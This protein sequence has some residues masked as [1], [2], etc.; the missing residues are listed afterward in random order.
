MDRLIAP[1]S[2]TAGAADVAPA[3][4]TPGFATDG[5]PAT[6]T[7][8]TIWPAYQVN[9]FQEELMAV[10]AAA[11]I[12]PDRTKNNQV[13]A[14]ITALLQSGVT[15]AAPD[16]GTVNAL[17]VTL[18][19]AP[20]ALSAG[21]QA[22][23]LNV[24]ATN[25]AAATLNLNGLG[26]KPIVLPSGAALSGGEIYAGSAATFVY[27][28]SSWML[29]TRQPATGV[30]S[31]TFA[32]VA[33]LTSNQGP[34]YVSDMA[35]IYTWVSTAYFTGYR[36][37]DCGRWYGGVSDTPQAWELIANGG[38]WTTTNPAHARVIAR[39]QELG[40]TVA[41]GSWTAGPNLI[42]S[43]GSGNWMGPD[44]RNVFQRMSGTDADT[45][46]AAPTGTYK[47]DTLKSHT[48]GLGVRNDLPPTGGS[49]AFAPGYAVSG[50]TVA[51]GTAETAPKHVRVAP[52]ILI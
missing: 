5:N 47:S 38:T 7:P 24:A 10:I 52:V 15:V 39:Y 25:T 50:Q 13:A 35:H 48:H 31:M 29:Q 36:N 40:L 19:P 6:N 23:A 18:T 28:G 43:L 26:V 44:L 3:T 11:N 4:G 51:V 42:A 1:Y 49:V 2:V 46:N 45:A 33:A 32:Q 17:A 16:S 12:T 27:T 37:P 9:A 21:M 34:I 30:P 14:A 41:Q 8:A 22:T 20:T